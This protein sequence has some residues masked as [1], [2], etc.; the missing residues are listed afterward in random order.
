MTSSNLLPGPSQ[1][2]KVERERWSSAISFQEGQGS[3]QWWAVAKKTPNL[4]RELQALDCMQ[5]LIL[6][7]C[8]CAHCF[9]TV[10]SSVLCLSLWVWYLCVQCIQNLHA[11][12]WFG[13]ILIYPAGNALSWLSFFMKVTDN[14]ANKFKRF[15]SVAVIYKCFSFLFLP[16]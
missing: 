15:P 13:F 1:V 10:S 6:E 9:P 16:T 12:M 8:S 2:F 11:Q 4:V 7:C 5:K 14:S 3:E